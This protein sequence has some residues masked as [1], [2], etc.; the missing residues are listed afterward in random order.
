[1]ER[2]LLTSARAER[3]D[4]YSILAGRAM[5]VDA[6]AALQESPLFLPRYAAARVVRSLAA[7]R[8]SESDLF[9]AGQAYVA[10]REFLLPQTHEHLRRLATRAGA[11]CERDALAAAHVAPWA[12][13]A[14]QVLKHMTGVQPNDA[15]ARAFCEAAARVRAA[16]TA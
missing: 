11:R 15:V 1:M 2:V 3:A 5:R 14:S 10:H 6:L 4:V 13:D 16:Y 9:S 7:A 12:E 8:K